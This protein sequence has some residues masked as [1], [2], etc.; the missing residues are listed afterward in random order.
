MNSHVWFVRDDFFP[1]LKTVSKL[2]RSRKTDLWES[3]PKDLGKQQMWNSWWYSGSAGSRVDRRSH[4]E[5]RKKHKSVSVC[6][7]NL[8]CPC[9]L[10]MDDGLELCQQAP[11]YCTHCTSSQRGIISLFH[12]CGS[13]TCMKQEFRQKFWLPHKKVSRLEMTEAVTCWGCP[14][15]C[16]LFHFTA[17]NILQDFMILRE[18]Q[19]LWEGEEGSTT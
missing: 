4:L 10:C 15:T 6:A 17:K 5:R 14:H 13:G 7:E 2:G 19:V 8:L 1:P 11:L 16:S 3:L 9:V 12:V 18:S